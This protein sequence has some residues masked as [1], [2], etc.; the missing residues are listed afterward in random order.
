MKYDRLIWNY[1]LRG[2]GIAPNGE[3]I[4]ELLMVGGYNAGGHDL[5]VHLAIFFMWSISCYCHQSFFRF[6][7]DAL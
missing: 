6:E 7:E 4:S 3:L 5:V 2:E 1:F